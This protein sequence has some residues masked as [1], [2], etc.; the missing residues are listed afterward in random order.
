L[1]NMAILNTEELNVMVAKYRGFFNE[2]LHRQVG[3][4]MGD[5]NIL[6]EKHTD[7]FEDILNQN[8]EYLDNIKEL[9]FEEKRELLWLDVLDC[10][11]VV[12]HKNVGSSSIDQDVLTVLTPLVVLDDLFYFTRELQDYRQGIDK[13]K[14]PEE[15]VNEI[16]KDVSEKKGY[17]NRLAAYR[18]LIDFINTGK[19]KKTEVYEVLSELPE[20]KQKELMEVYGDDCISSLAPK[21]KNSKR[22]MTA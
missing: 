9:S 14:T 13:A 11:Q 21:K 7:M 2:A 15:V 22:K 19:F 12:I 4:I 8:Y 16:M 6:T 3:K 18:C 5:D 10:I 17:Y 1:I 20:D